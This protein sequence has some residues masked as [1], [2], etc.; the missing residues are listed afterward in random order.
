MVIVK[1]STMTKLHNCSRNL[2]RNKWKKKTSYIYT[3]Q[4]W[5]ATRKSEIMSSEWKMDINRCHDVKIKTN[6]TWQVSYGHL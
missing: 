1:L 4:Y 3:M 6:I 5:Y 2:L